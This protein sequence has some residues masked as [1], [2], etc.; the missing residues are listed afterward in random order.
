MDYIVF[1][2]LVGVSLLLVVLSYDIGCQ[3]SKN[4]KKREHEFPEKMWM[5]DSFNLEVKVPSWHVNGH[6]DFC[7]TQYSLNY[8]TGAGRT[9]G[10]DVETTC[11]H[12]NALGTSVREMG[13]ASRHELLN[14][15]WNGWNFRKIVGFVGLGSCI[16]MF[17]RLNI[18]LGK[19]FLK[20]FNDAFNMR[21][22][23]RDIFARLTATFPSNT[24]HKWDTIVK[25][26]H[27]DPSRPRTKPNP[28]EEPRSGK[29]YILVYC[30][31]LINHSL[32][33]TVQDIRLELVQ[34]EA[35]EVNHGVLPPHKISMSSFLTLGLELEEQQ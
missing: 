6:G 8:L 26:W 14:D 20:R 15:H 1:S 2:T 10:E 25:E 16:R 11:A 33:T 7:R 18:L 17:S 21:Q 19:L 3:W 12:S 34:E 9:C 24:V 32:A 28:Y 35:D 31:W 13:P 22:K 5:D 30:L 23:H 27:M 4:L 29:K